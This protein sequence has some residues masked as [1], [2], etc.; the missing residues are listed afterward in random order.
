M[1]QSMEVITNVVSHANLVF[2]NTVIH[3]LN[4]SYEEERKPIS[5]FV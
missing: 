5:F 3:V 1:Y 2:E 4:A